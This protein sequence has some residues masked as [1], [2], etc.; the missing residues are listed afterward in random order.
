MLASLLVSVLLVGFKLNSVKEIVAS[1]ERRKEL[2]RNLAI[3]QLG[4]EEED[5]KVWLDNLAHDTAQRRKTMNAMEPASTQVYTAAEAE[6]IDK[7]TAAFAQYDSNPAPVE[8]LK[9]SVTIAR[10]ETKRHEDGRLL[11]GRAEAEVAAGPLEIVA[12]MLN[13]DSRHIRSNWNRA[14]DVRVDI[15][16]RV[17][18][19]HIIVFNRRKSAGFSDRTFLNETIAK[20]VADDPT[21]YI[22]VSLPIAEH[23]KITTKDE[24]GAVRAE[25]F[26]SFRFTEMAPGRSKMEATLRFLPSFWHALHSPDFMSVCSTC[27]H[28]TYTDSFRSL[29]PTSSW[30]RRQ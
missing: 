1:L 19:H 7:G 28:S 25:A 11:L 3:L 5:L 16:D 13:Y 8:Q 6:L 9:R 10:S 30:S 18:D 22:L 15:V 20:Q 27:A 17:N 23:P 29:L 21:T 4:L 26:R 14:V 2:E 12:Y 24:A